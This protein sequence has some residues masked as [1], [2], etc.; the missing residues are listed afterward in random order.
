[1][2]ELRQETEKSEKISEG[3]NN[4]PTDNNEENPSTPRYNGVPREALEKQLKLIWKDVARLAT[5]RRESMERKTLR[6]V[7]STPN[8]NTRKVLDSFDMDL[9]SSYGLQ[10]SIPQEEKH[11]SQTYEEMMAEFR[12]NYL[13]INDNKIT[14]LGNNK[15]DGQYDGEEF[16]FGSDANNDVAG[17]TS[18]NEANRRKDRRSRRRAEPS[19]PVDQG[20]MPSARSFPT[21]GSAATSNDIGQ[22]YSS[23]S[24]NTTN[25]DSDRATSGQSSS[26]AGRRGRRKQFQSI[27]SEFA[28]ADAV[29]SPPRHSARLSDVAIGGY[30]SA[31]PPPVE[32]DLAITTVATMQK[33]KQQQQQTK[34]LLSD[35]STQL[36]AMLNRAEHAVAFDDENEELDTSMFRL[37]NEN[38]ND[39]NYTNENTSNSNM[40]VLSSKASEESSLRSGAVTPSNNSDMKKMQSRPKR[41]STVI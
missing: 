2:R 5:L 17:N 6:S 23:S 36:D 29:P 8:T 22:T 30:S 3:N 9:E 13:D 38:I 4:S 7:S 15:I 26:S 32:L 33:K 21:A 31:A 14:L 27:S 37:N 35:M 10:S 1:M 20:T 39:N 25:D 40:E 34:M 19:S 18:S 12:L 41:K 11:P 16:G 24:M 28:L